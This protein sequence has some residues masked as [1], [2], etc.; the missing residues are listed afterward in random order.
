MQLEKYAKLVG[1]NPIIDRALSDHV[2]WPLLCSSD[3][4]M[5]DHRRLQWVQEKLKY[6]AVRPWD[7]LDL[8]LKDA[9]LDMTH[10]YHVIYLHI[11][12]SANE[13]PACR[14]RYTSSCDDSESIGHAMTNLV[15]WHKL[16]WAL[17]DN[18]PLVIDAVV[19][20]SDS[21]RQDTRWTDELIESTINIWLTPAGFQP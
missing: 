8:S 12:G 9:R 3:D 1:S 10:M 13:R 17:Q 14:A 19:R 2:G 7:K 5:S 4:P 18:C 21:W 16:Y 20:R 15:E 6:V 11:G